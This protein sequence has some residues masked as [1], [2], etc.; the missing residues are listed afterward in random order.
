MKSELHREVPYI[1]PKSASP[2][3][4]PGGK[5]A[6][7]AVACG[8]AS[9]TS[10]GNQDIPVEMVGAA[11]G[12]DDIF[13]ALIEP[14]LKNSGAGTGVVVNVPG[15]ATGSSIIIVDEGSIGETVFIT[16]GK[17][18]AN[19]GA[20]CCFDSSLDDIFAITPF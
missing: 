17:G 19:E 2:T 7:Q 13:Q 18:R 15:I 3:L 5:S 9:S 12:D 14:V 6:N 10:P 11:G 16:G 8:R 20:G 1:N 4:S